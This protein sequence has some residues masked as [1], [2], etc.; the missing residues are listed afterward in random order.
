MRWTSINENSVRGNLTSTKQSQSAMQAPQ[1][2]TRVISYKSDCRGNGVQKQLD[3]TLVQ[4]HPYLPSSLPWRRLSKRGSSAS[5]CFSTLCCF[6]LLG[7]VCLITLS[8]STSE[9]LTRLLLHCRIDFCIPWRTLY[10]IPLLS[11][12][13]HHG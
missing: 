1:K 5:L 10:R 8:R 4:V 9:L 6:Y 13:R 11:H 3:R 2:N 7:V 12:S